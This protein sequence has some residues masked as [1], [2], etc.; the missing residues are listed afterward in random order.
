MQSSSIEQKR[1]VALQHQQGLRLGAV[2]MAKR[3]V[4]KKFA[5]AGYCSI[6]VD[7]RLARKEI[8]G[9]HNLE[10]SAKRIIRLYELSSRKANSKAILRHNL[11]ATF[12]KSL[13]V[14]TIAEEQCMK[15]ARAVSTIQDTISRFTPETVRP[16]QGMKLY[17]AMLF[18]S[19]TSLAWHS[20]EK[21]IR[22]K[23]EER[24]LGLG[25]A[26]NEIKRAV[27]NDIPGSISEIGYSDFSAI[28]FSGSEMVKQL[29]EGK[30]F[31]EYAKIGF[32]AIDK[33]VQE[34][35]GGKGR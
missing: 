20:K 25:K 18:I 10:G 15:L 16:T 30:G 28:S 13:T 27:N 6:P 9:K 21:L 2:R 33:I 35:F 7:R 22:K 14:R 29:R 32:E 1:N 31:S 17:Q 5:R 23:L 4:R 8:A 34:N 24:I 3:N 26:I 11:Q 12:L 19:Q